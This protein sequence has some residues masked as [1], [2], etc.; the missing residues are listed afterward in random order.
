MTEKER[1]FDEIQIRIKERAK[2]NYEIALLW[3]KYYGRTGSKT[4]DGS[5]ESA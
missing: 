3:D 2:L 4:V 1:L 5:S